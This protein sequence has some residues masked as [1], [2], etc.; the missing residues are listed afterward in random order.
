VKKIIASIFVIVIFVY[1]SSIAQEIKY[2]KVT[3]KELEEKFYPLDSSANAVVL[4]KKR[5][6]YY[7]Y[8]NSSGWTLITEVHERIKFYNKDGFDYATNKVPIY[9]R[10]GKSESFVI[11]AYTYNLKGGKIE[12]TKLSKS[13]IFDEEITENWGSKNF[14]MPNL[15]VGSVIEWTY[16]IASPYFW[17]INDVICQYDIP[18]KYMEFKIQIPED[19]VFKY[20][21]SRYYPIDVKESKIQKNYSTSTQEREGGKGYSGVKSTTEY[22]NTKIVETVYATKTEKIPALIKEVYVNNMNNYRAKVKFEITAY[23][24]KYGTHEYYNNTWNDVAKTIYKSDYFGVQLDKTNYFRED[25]NSIT[26]GLSLPK[27]K[28]SAI[29]E[30]VKNKI[31]WNQVYS[32]YTSIGGVKKAYKEGVGNVAEINLILVAML[33]E[34]GLDANPILISTRSHGIPLF[35]TSN[36]FNYI[37]V[38]VET[39]QGVVLLDATE[40]YCSPNVLPLRDLNW[41]GQMIREQGSTTSISL[42]PNKYNTKMVNLTS[43][44]N[45][46]GTITGLM[47]TTYNRLNALQYRVENNALSNN[48]LISKLEDNNDIEIEKFRLTN[49]NNI[50]KPLVEMVQFSREN[51]VDIIGNKIYLSPMLFLKVRENP[52]KQEE[53]SYPVDYGSPWKN[54]TKISIQIPNGY[55]I[56]SKP[57]DISLVLPDNLGIYNLKSKV[58]N[59][60]INVTS[61]TKINKAIIG[62]NYYKTLKDLYKQVIDKQLEKIVLVKS[63]P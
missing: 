36:G 55:S 42:Y 54:D 12:K 22:N 10:G 53:R 8:N 61:Q 59:N 35:P 57:E 13:D 18:I 19:F 62:S 23:T 33:R 1:T 27:D 20:V 43:K 34:S 60:K 11:K 47:T 44:L 52:F 50:S 9:S 17:N 16:T 26:D 45:I 4:Y 3:K 15:K 38:G 51:Q 37:I 29:F 14:T 39:L 7:N 63:E 48:D 24:P 41:E 56:E 28:I 30:F 25:L 32:K 58:V 31:K 2:G 40:K 46:D 6:T 21:T 5:R 49:L